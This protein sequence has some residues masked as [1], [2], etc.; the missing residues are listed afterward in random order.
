MHS[1]ARAASARALGSPMRSRRGRWS[2][3]RAALFVAS[4]V[5]CASIASAAVRCPGDLD[6]DRIVKIDELLAI[7]G[8]ALGV[9]GKQ[10]R[11]DLDGDGNVGID[12]VVSAVRVA[13][14]GCPSTF[15]PLNGPGPHWIDEVESGLLTFDAVATVGLDLTGDGVGDSTVTVEGTTTVFRSISVPGNPAEPG[16]R[17]HLGLEIVDMVLLAEGIRFRAGDGR[18][19]L[20]PDG[21][22]HS[23]GTS[24]EVPGSPET[25]LDLF[26]VHFE[27]EVGALR[28]HNRDPLMVE[29]SIDRLPPIGNEFRFDGP[30]LTLYNDAG[31]PTAL[32]V[33]FVRYTPL[34]PDLKR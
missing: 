10:P 11:G 1:S 26:A 8:E 33:T 18:G 29:A 14:R 15:F 9:G 30:P 32:A 34:D 24:D 12:E 21:P 4:G 28:L 16:H 7:V 17:N 23:I 20:K 13:Q 2:C 19:N 5:V 3:T 27:V 6:G 25:A 22:L 31:A